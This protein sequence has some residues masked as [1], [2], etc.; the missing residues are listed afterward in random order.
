M[1][2]APP[3]ASVPV[4]GRNAVVPADG[5]LAATP[6]PRMERAWRTTWFA[7]SAAFLLFPVVHLVSV[8]AAPLETALAL[9]AVVVFGLVLARALLI[10]D[11]RIGDAGLLLPIQSLTLLAIAAALT[12]GWPTSGWTAVGYFASVSAGG[13]LPE[14]RALRL[15]GLCGIVMATAVVASGSG[16]WDGALTGLGIA[17]IG[18][19][20]FA[21]NS[22]RRTNVAL[23]SA[24]AELARLAV[25]EERERIARDLHDTLGHSLS[26]IT[27]KSEL[28]GRLLPHDPI[29]ARREIGDVETTAREALASVRETVR[30][31]RKPS[32]DAE[33]GGLVAALRAAGISPE[34]Q[35]LVIGL[36]EPADSLF[37]WAV[38]EGVTNVMRHSGATHCTIRIGARGRSCLRRGRGRWSRGPR[39]GRSCRSRCDRTGHGGLGPARPGRACCRPGR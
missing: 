9:A 39:H 19:A 23:V 2:S 4:G 10:D 36:P 38:R 30:G 37:A 25:L 15:M 22:L 14:R 28:A 32:L 34:V 27:L 6:A 12:Y 31:F 1:S 11:G 33:L 24:R 13:V 35:R 8:P 16:F 17:V 26:L 3:D 29:A 18:F 20:V 5:R 7:A 21:L